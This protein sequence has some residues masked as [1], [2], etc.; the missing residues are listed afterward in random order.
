VQW[1][2]NKD[3]ASLNA[4][5]AGR[6]GARWGGGWQAQNAQGAYVLNVHV[7]NYTAAEDAQLSADLGPWYNLLAV[8]TS[9]YSV[10]DIKTAQATMHSTAAAHP[11]GNLLSATSQDVV[12][13]SVHAYMR[14]G[15]AA[16][17]I[18]LQAA[19]GADMITAEEADIQLVQQADDFHREDGW[20]RSRTQLATES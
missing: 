11:D 9:K 6:F 4:Q 16:L 3:I 7:K 5:L 8:T 19:V 14:P 12:N 15:G 2:A 17:L 1:Q 18:A 13:N 10:D 20:S